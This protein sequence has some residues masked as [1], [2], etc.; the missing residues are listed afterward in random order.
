MLSYE[1]QLKELDMLAWAEAAWEGRVGTA[2]RYSSWCQ[3][4]PLFLSCPRNT[5]LSST[6]EEISP[7]P[8]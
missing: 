4:A 8:P 5:E 6:D 1:K 2:F 7:P 3:G